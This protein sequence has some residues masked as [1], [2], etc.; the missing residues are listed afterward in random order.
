[1]TVALDAL[2][3]QPMCSIRRPAEGR[4]RSA[5]GRSHGLSGGQSGERAAGPSGGRATR[6]AVGRLAGPR[7]PRSLHPVPLQ[8][9]GCAIYAEGCTALAEARTSASGG[10]L[11]SSSEQHRTDV[12]LILA[13]LAGARQSLLDSACLGADFDQIRA[14]AHFTKCGRVSDTRVWAELGQMC[15]LGSADLGPSST[16]AGPTPA[17]KC[18]CV[19]H[20]HTLL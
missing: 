10:A 9:V 15:V 20:T 11:A 1:M 18:V 2:G 8:E 17:Q 3:V 13:A 19:E 12:Y 14:D 5:G 6:R 4:G 16:K 7:E